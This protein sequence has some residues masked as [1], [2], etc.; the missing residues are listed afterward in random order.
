MIPCPG[1]VDCKN[2]DGEPEEITEE[3]VVEVDEIDP[4]DPN[5]HQIG[6]IERFGTF[7]KYHNSSVGHF[8]ISR[9]M[10]A[11]QNLEFIGLVCLWI[12]LNGSMWWMPE[13]QAAGRSLA[14]QGGASLIQFRSSHQGW[15]KELW[16]ILL[17][18]QLTH[19]QPEWD[20]AGSDLA[21]DLSREWNNR[22]IPEFLLK[23]REMQTR[24]IRN[25]HL[26]REK[27]QSKRARKGH[28]SPEEVP[29]LR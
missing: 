6:A 26:Y 25:T 14:R 22:E 8:E 11:M 24:L 27:N 4:D 19:S 7:K 18:D 23:L 17:T 2:K 13:D 9:A 28:G 5:K 3:V 16:I 1:S 12:Y 10:E 21:M 29:G 20:I 15:F